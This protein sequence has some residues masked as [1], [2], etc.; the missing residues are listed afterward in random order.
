M[1]G[2]QCAASDCEDFESFEPAFD[3]FLFE[4]D[5][6]PPAEW[7]PHNWVEVLSPGGG[8]PLIV[9]IADMGDN[10]GVLFVTE[11]ADARC[12]SG[13]TMMI[14]S[15]PASADAIVSSTGV[16]LIF[17]SGESGLRI[18]RCMEGAY[19]PIEN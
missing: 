6:E 9:V 5:V 15:N 14:S 1:L 3:R 17:V 4:E 16:P 12:L 2:V 13:R 19:E 18:I 11:C 7:W 10:E 8:P